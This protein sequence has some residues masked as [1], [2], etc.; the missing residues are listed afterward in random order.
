[1]SVR[2]IGID[3]VA[4][5]R[6]E[7]LLLRHG[8]RFL[9]RCFRPGE[10]PGRVPATPGAAFAARVAGRWAVKEAVLKALGGELGAVPYRDIE[11]GRSPD[12]A[13]VVT[14]HGR[15]AAA[16]AARGGGRVL[17]SLSHERD[18]AVGLAVIEG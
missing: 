14:L 16:F 18:Q 12:G 9:E 8:D 3:I 11:V 6:L 5:A 1:L 7:A 17:V 10:L 4:V 15:A 2:G 13:P